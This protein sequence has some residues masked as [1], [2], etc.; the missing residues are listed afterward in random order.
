MTGGVKIP[1]DWK[2][3][4]ILLCQPS[5]S[6]LQVGR[7]LLYQMLFDHLQSTGII[8]CIFLDFSILYLFLCVT[9]SLIILNWKIAALLLFPFLKSIWLSPSCLST[10]GVI[11]CI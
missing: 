4:S 3:H 5:P 8:S 9:H 6:P 7:A 1:G 10:M 11:R 2:Y